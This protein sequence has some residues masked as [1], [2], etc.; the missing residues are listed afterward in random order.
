MKTKYNF[1]TTYCSRKFI[2][3]I[4]LVIVF[5]SGCENNV[6]LPKVES[7]KTNNLEKLVPN[8]RMQI[9]YN[10]NEMVFSPFWP[11]DMVESKS[12]LNSSDSQ[13]LVDYDNTHVKIAIDEDGYLHKKSIYIEGNSEMHMPEDLYQSLS[14]IMPSPPEDYDPIVGYEVMNGVMKHYTQSGEVVMENPIDIEK[15]RIDPELLDSLISNQSDTSVSGRISRNL[16]ILENNEVNF[17]QL[18]D[19]H[20]LVSERISN[21]TD[22]NFEGEYQELFDLSIG[23]AIRTAT[24]N[25][26]GQYLSYNQMSYKI[27]N[28]FPILEHSDLIQFGYRNNEWSIINRTVLNRTNIELHLID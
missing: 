16:K 20:V 15:M 2:S 19:K 9:S 1:N 10:Q 11:D 3:M 6:L 5:F 26:S 13:F 12:K 14:D 25:S 7:D 22:S 24:K 23:K 18:T 27:I 8:V 21:S 4:M 17:N 28:N